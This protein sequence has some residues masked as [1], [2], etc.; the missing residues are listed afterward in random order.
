MDFHRISEILKRVFSFLFFFF[1]LENSFDE[2]KGTSLY[3]EQ[4]NR[5]NRWKERERVVGRSKVGTR[6]NFLFIES[7]V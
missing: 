5:E 7:Y 4:K 1:M 2:K 3:V 6:G